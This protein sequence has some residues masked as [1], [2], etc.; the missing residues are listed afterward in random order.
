V[1]RVSNGIIVMV[2]DLDQV[3]TGLDMDLSGVQVL[4][5]IV[6]TILLLGLILIT[7]QVITV[8]EV[9]VGNGIHM[10][11]TKDGLLDQ[12][13]TPHVDLNILVRTTEL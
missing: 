5:P 6:T 10:V 11:D 12:H 13:V 2:M 9:S 4:H 1:L 7:V 3:Q 8:V